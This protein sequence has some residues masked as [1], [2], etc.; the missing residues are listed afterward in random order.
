MDDTN[1]FFI[2]RGQTLSFVDDP[3]LAGPEAAISF[4]SDGTI[5]IES[6]KI[7]DC[8]TASD[9]LPQYPKARVEHYPNDLILSGFVD[10]HVH[11]PQV[12][13]MAAYGEQLLDWLD[14]YTFPAESKFADET[15][16]RK[17]ADIFLDQSLHNGTTSASVYATVHPQS[18]D[19]FFSA[20]E[21][22]NMCMASGKILMDRNAPDYLLDTAQTGYDQSKALIEKW[23]GRDRLTYAITPRFA[24]T[25]TPSQLE[26]VGT[27]WHEHP[28]A[29][30]QTHLSENHNEI[31]LVR[32]QFPD[33]PDYFG[34]YEKFG[35]VGEG[36]NFGHAI[37]L[38]ERE[39]SAFAETRSGISHC[40]T[41][42][43]F[44]G[45][46]LMD[47]QA[48]RDG[49]A[50]IPVGLAS[51]IG[52]GSSLSMFHT[53]KAS[54]EVC[55]LNGYNLHPAKAF[56]L[57]TLGSADV[58]RLGHRIGNIANGYDADII[59]VDLQS[60]PAI[61]NR[62]S[63]ARDLAETLFIQ[64]MM[65]DDRAIRATYIAGNKLYNR[66]N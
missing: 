48:L 53:M 21:A 46:G 55:R 25:S 61:A 14:R 57:A 35:L 52:G 63:Y 34:V 31:A 18:A 3:F 39:R 56:Y 28:S 30:M 16:A 1:N 19:A 27:L 13:V 44:L 58:M 59:V 36:A 37:H 6:G 42:N 50:K 17:V 64:M 60:T 65:A 54:Y 4:D 11:Y 32:S 45:S 15:Y 5:V 40:P 49:E 43:L 51:D 20:A 24:V 62:M 22:R 12:E 23:H 26:A 29:L 7:K 47:M 8:G 33:C 38:S 66:T 9:I 10:C 41:S 2:L